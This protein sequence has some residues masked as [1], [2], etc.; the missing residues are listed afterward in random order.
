VPNNGRRS[1]KKRSVTDMIRE[2][3]GPITAKFHGNK[4]ELIFG[5]P[6]PAPPPKAE[7]PPAPKIEEP[8]VPGP[9]EL[10]FVN[11]PG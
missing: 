9:G 7:A 8:Y 4:V 6:T 2:L 5:E 3:Y 11:D 1:N 10:P